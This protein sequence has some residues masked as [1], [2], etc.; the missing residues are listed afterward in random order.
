[1]PNLD[2]CITLRCNAHCKNCIELC[3]MQEVTGIDYSDS[4][5]TLSQIDN[6]IDQVQAQGRQQV[7]DQVGVTGGEPLLHPQVEEI[8][9]RLD[10]LYAVGIFKNLYINSNLK[11]PAIPSLKK[12]ILNYTPL[13]K[14]PLIHN[15]MLL[16]PTDIGATPKTRV[17]CTHYR[18]DTWVLNYLGFSLCCAGD[19]YGRLFGRQDLIL[20]HLPKSVKDF[21]NM[22]AICLHCPFSSDDLVPLE[23][24]RGCPVS[25]IY[26]AEIVKNKQCSRLTKR[27]PGKCAAEMH[28]PPKVAW[29]CITYNRPKL[30]GHLIQCFLDQDYPDKQMI[31]LDD[32]G[33]YKNQKGNGWEIVSI[34]RRFATVGEKRNAV[35]A[36]VPSDVDIICPVD[37][38]DLYLPHA[39]QACVVA[40][41]NADWVIPSAVYQEKAN[42]V[43]SREYYHGHHSSWAYRQS[44]YR[45]TTGYGTWNRG[46]DGG[47]QVQLERMNLRV[48]DPVQMGFEPYLLYPTTQE[49]Y[50]CH[51]FTRD[52]QYKKMSQDIEEKCTLLIKPGYEKVNGTYRLLRQ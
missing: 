31:I 25:S 13:E 20:D 35:T 15:T 7:F 10:R 43:F 23:K 1:M 40:M 36:L 22:D 34:P 48:A 41:K 6:F 50:H 9:K 27:F 12:Y 49:T 24:D 16:H 4:D 2:I 21:P 33:Q 30:L 47:L 8:V 37:D 18:K 39:M 45:Q 51:T 42:G 28:N 5:M 19:A 3:N 32:A 44:V 52:E 11:I 38:D 46:E 26:A 29:V 14:K 17:Q